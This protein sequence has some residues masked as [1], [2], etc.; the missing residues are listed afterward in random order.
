MKVN[1]ALSGGAS[2]GIAHIG[3]IKALE[4]LGFEISAVSGVSAGALVGAFYCDGYSPE[5][6]L[7][8]VKSRDWLR[9][10]R[11]TVPRLGLVSLK[12]AEVYLRGMLSV[13]RIEELKKRL[14][15][16]AVD[17]KS[18]K[19]HYFD[20]GSLF[21][22]LLGSCALPGIFEPVR[23]RSHL[24]MDGGITN[25]LPVE[26]LIDME[27]LLVGVDVNPNAPIEKVGN[28]FQILVRSFLLAVRS[29]VEK[30]KELCHVV[31]EPELY[32]YSPLSLL[33]AE[34]IYRLGYE[35]TMQVMRSYAR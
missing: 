1:L 34:E 19:T 10:L 8:V 25:N 9:Y 20:S 11:P 15:I 6:M 16:G 13:D 30:R 26:P 4:E 17:L 12:G 33:K 29:N 3:V 28:I 23:Y 22:I 31:I 5:E 32:A 7:R 24:L 2:R 21:P 27:G 14:F 35:K 18:G